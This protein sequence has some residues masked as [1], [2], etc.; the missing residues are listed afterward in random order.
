M[1]KSISTFLKHPTKD[2]SNR[3]ANPPVTRASTILFDTMQELYNH[4]RK[5]K[6]HQKVSHYSYGRYGSTTTIELENILKEL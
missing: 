5:I 3:S 6:R 2:L 1:K 4:E